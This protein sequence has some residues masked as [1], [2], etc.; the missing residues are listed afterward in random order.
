MALVFST[1]VVFADISIGQDTVLNLANRGKLDSINS[2]ILKQ[3]RYIQVFTP[4]NYK[5]DSS[6]KYD[7][8]Y[9]LDGGNWNTGPVSQIQSFVEGQG[10]MP[11][12]IILSVMG[13]NRNKEL[14][15][16]HLENWKGSGDAPNFLAYIKNELVP[17]I[18]KNYP[19]NNVNTLWGHS[20]SGLFVVYAMLNEPATFKSYIAVD[21]SIWW[22]NCHIANVIRAKLPSLHAD[23]ITLFV[24]G[25]DSAAIKDMK[26]DTLDAL[27]KQLSPK[28]LK[29]KIVSYPDESHSTV[30]LKTTYDGL[31]FT[32]SGLSGM[33]EFHPMNGIVSKTEPFKV[34][35]FAD[36]TTGVHFTTDGTVP[37]LFSP[38]ARR[39]TVLRGPVKISFKRFTSR[40][41]YDKMQTGEFITE[42]PPQPVPKPKHLKP[43]G[44]HYAYYEG[45]WFTWPDLKNE[46]PLR[47]GVTD[48]NFDL[49]S[50]PRKS[51]Y[52]LIVNGFLEVKQ[53]GYHI[54][55]LEADKNSKL[56]LGNRLLITWDGN[57]TR[58]AFSSI[59]TLKKGFYP[60]R[61]EYLHKNPD[62]GLRMF[63]LTP[64]KMSN[65]DPGPVP[66]DFQYHIE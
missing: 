30:R 27:L 31:R 47:A 58:R 35:Y 8:L 55:A 62:F 29:W 43:G 26:I 5:P 42:R 52:A 23:N 20:L 3:K 49:D 1:L 54:F 2:Q 16:T 36:D 34:W 25:R 65:P 63:Y 37:T 66:L 40:S 56:Y 48:K 38:Q 6:L 7:V 57:Y 41:Q 51:N 61:M 44:F 22:D 18:N 17:Y 24:G 12:T 9:V 46:K 21:P 28:G 19:S 50:L 10:D 4:R 39:E 33:V 59:V 14:T 64:D 11:P 15:P 13:I 45:E 60:L 53:D 32:Y